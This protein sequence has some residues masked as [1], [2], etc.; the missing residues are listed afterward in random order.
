M[1][2]HQPNPLQTPL[3][4]NQKTPHPLDPK[5]TRLRHAGACVQRVET[6]PSRLACVPGCCL[7]MIRAEFRGPAAAV[8]MGD[9]D[10]LSPGDVLTV[11]AAA[12]APA[13]PAAARSSWHGA[14]LSA[15]SAVG[16]GVGQ[17][18]GRRSSVLQGPAAR[19]VSGELPG[20]RWDSLQ[21]YLS[22]GQ[23]QVSF[24]TVCVRSTCRRDC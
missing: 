21:R 15:S 4:V 19:R 14:L 17:A 6:V 22:S 13:A 8:I 2:A 18:P 9:L 20:Q 24:G 1:C 3:A 11:P 5:P 10:D 7:Q 16:A 12:G 23:Q